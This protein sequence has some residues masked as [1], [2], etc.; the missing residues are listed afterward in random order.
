L[1]EDPRPLT[2]EELSAVQPDDVR[3]RLARSQVFSVRLSAAE[4][5]TIADEAGRLG[6]TAG[7]F[8]KRAAMDAAEVHRYS[9]P[10]V[11]SVAIAGTGF[12]V[13]ND[14]A[15]SAGI[16]VDAPGERDAVYPRAARVV[17]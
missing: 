10:S 4:L 8:I 5:R 12:V 6:L 3:V 13:L 15:S 1:Q 16:T 7:A 11:M 17:A 9:T 14:V 2:E